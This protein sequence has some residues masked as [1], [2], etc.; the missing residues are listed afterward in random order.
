MTYNLS[1]VRKILTIKKKLPKYSIL[2]QKKYI[3]S[4][5]LKGMGESVFAEFTNSCIK[6]EAVN[7][8]QGFPNYAP[9]IFVQECLQEVSKMGVIT[10]QY[11]RSM[12]HPI[13]VNQLQ[14]VYESLFSRKLTQMN[15]VITNGATGALFT[16]C[17]ALLNPG[18]VALLLEP[19]YDSYPNQVQMAGGVCKYLPFNIPKN[20]VSSEELSIDFKNLD[21]MIS[22]KTKLLFINNPH[23]PTGKCWSKEEFLELSNII[24]RHP[25]LLVVL[26]E[27]Y[28]WL[29]F[30]NNQH[31][32]FASLPGMWNRTITVGSAG[33]SFE[34]TG[35]K[36]G[37]IC[38]SEKITR[39]IQMAHQWIPF[40]TSIP[41]QCAIGLSFKKQ[42]EVNWFEHLRYK[43]QARRDSLMNGLKLAGMRVIVPQGG[44]FV[45][46]DTSSFEYNYNPHEPKDFEFARWLIQ[47]HKLGPIPP[48]AFYSSTNRHLVKDYARFAFCKSDTLI[49]AGLERLKAIKR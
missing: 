46:V 5:R 19:F 14:N 3:S 6:N 12:G 11:N 41:L 29:I 31:V 21:D 44:Y 28:E 15:F 23:N 22:D 30:D 40:C 45:L 39:L 42:S 34:C 32:R 9:P 49:E 17:Q 26:D 8:G 10:N 27:A 13:L 43:L 7:L 2:N 48:S 4:S 1:Q 20:C 25:N 38:A 16:I 24:L 37:W 18:D 33:K 36:I 35:W 47:T